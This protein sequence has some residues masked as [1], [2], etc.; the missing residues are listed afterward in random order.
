VWGSSKRC[1]M[2]F[3]IEKPEAHYKNSCHLIS[4]L[5]QVLCDTVLVCVILRLTPNI[6]IM[7]RSH[8]SN[9]LQIARHSQIIVSPMTSTRLLRGPVYCDSTTS[10][11]TVISRTV[12]LVITSYPATQLHRH[13]DEATPNKLGGSTLTRSKDGAAQLE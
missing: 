13:D 1:E 11:A 8:L 9:H 10:P 6:Y 4:R 7:E 2:Y 12:Q 5:L 3:K